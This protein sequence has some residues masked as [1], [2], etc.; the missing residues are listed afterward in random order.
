MLADTVMLGAGVTLAV[1][2]VPGPDTDRLTIIIYTI[3]V[4]LSFCFLLLS[5]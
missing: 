1:E 2:G 3:M 5:M 4:A